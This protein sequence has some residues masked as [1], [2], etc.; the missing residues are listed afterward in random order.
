MQ[1]KGCSSSSK[2][3]ASSIR[4]NNN[5]LGGVIVVSFYLC[6]DF[7]AAV[8]SVIATGDTVAPVAVVCTPVACDTDYVTMRFV[9][10][11]LLILSVLVRMLWLV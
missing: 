4:T 11:L 7:C 3:T 9:I 1:K 2:D 5:Q 10:L 6:D 8:A